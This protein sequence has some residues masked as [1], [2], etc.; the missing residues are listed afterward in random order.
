MMKTHLENLLAAQHNLSKAT[1]ELADFWA[2][3]EKTR[4]R[5]ERQKLTSELMT[6]LPR[7]LDFGRTVD[8]IA[9]ACEVEL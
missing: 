5:S 7:P 4:N 9:K 3:D 8:K 1:Q 6:I 2:Q